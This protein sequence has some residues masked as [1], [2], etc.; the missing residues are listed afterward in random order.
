MQS[1]P[2]F[3]VKDRVGRRCRYKLDSWHG[4]LFEGCLERFAWFGLR[5]EGCLMRFA[6]WQ[7]YEED[8]RGCLERNH[9]LINM[10]QMFLISP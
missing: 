5:S 4:M 8:L 1:T 10:Y 6:S 3:I 2:C 9:Y 7:V